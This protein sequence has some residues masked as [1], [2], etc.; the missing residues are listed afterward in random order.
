[1]KLNE[2]HSREFAKDE[3]KGFEHTNIAGENL[4]IQGGNRTG[5]T[6][7]FN[8]ILYNLLGAQ[9]TIDLSTGR[10]N[11]VS[12]EFTDG[13]EFRRGK[14]G[15]RFRDGDIEKSDDEAQEELAEW[16]RKICLRRSRVRI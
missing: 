12:L 1:M 13:V 15:A 5:K 6:L 10:N 9:E 14:L 4:L 7:T 2:L 8:A 11:N 3:Y 16:L